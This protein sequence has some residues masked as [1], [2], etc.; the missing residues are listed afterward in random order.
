MQ[1]TLAGRTAL[2]TGAGRGIGRAIAEL[3]SA[4]GVRVAVADIDAQTAVATAETIGEGAVPIT[5]DVASVSDCRRGV[6]EALDALGTLDILVNNAGYLRFTTAFDCSE[7]DWDRIVDVNLKGMFFCAQAALAPMRDRGS[8]VIINMTSLAA[9]NG[10]NA[11]GPPYAA[12]KAGV[13]TL[14]I[15]LA[16]AMALHGVR[17]NAIA[18]GVIDTDMTRGLSPNHAKLAAQ[19]PLG[20][21]GRPEDVAA[22]ALFLASDAARHITGEII[23]VNGGLF[24][25]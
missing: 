19:I 13:H 1:Q 11:A 6:G 15:H 25:D 8:G 24:M 14:T 20:E 22:C 2:I 10:G 9:K 7:K 4:Q 16:R 12:A 23:D 5:L 21:K 3:F 18:P 17:V